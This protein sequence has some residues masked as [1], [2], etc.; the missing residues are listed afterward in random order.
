MADED[1]SAEDSERLEEHDALLMRQLKGERLSAVEQSRL[2]VLI[3][4]LESKDDENP[5]LPARVLKILD[6]LGV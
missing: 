1:W 4:W 2:Q 6:D 3:L 5:G